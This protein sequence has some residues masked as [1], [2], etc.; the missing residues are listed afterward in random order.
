MNWTAVGQLRCSPRARRT[1]RMGMACTEMR[2]NSVQAAPTPP[3]A[4]TKVRKRGSVM[5][6]IGASS[7]AGAID[8]ERP[9]RALRSVSTLISAAPP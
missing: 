3:R 9:E 8:R 4:V 1:T 7:T 5:P 6:S 2:R